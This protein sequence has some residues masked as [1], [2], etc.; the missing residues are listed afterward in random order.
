MIPS[1]LLFF[2]A[3]LSIVAPGAPPNIALVIVDDLAMDAMN[4]YRHLSG[5]VKV[6]STLGLH[7][8]FKHIPTPGID[9]LAAEGVLFSR[10]YTSAP[11]CSPSRYS[12]LVGRYPS[13]SK[14]AVEQSLKHPNAWKVTEGMGISPAQ[15]VP[16]R[17]GDGSR[18]FVYNHF[19]IWVGA[20][21]REEKTMA[22]ALSEAGFRT[23]LVGK[24]H[25]SWRQADPHAC[26]MSP[27]EYEEERKLVAETAGFDFVDALNT[28]NIQSSTKRGNRFSHNPEHTLHHAQ[29]FVLD[30]TAAQEPWFLYMG[31]TLPHPPNARLALSKYSVS[32]TPAGPGKFSG[33]AQAAE[34]RARWQTQVAKK[35]D[36]SVTAAVASGYKGSW[37]KNSHNSASIVWLDA[38][39]QEWV[40]WLKAQSLAD[41]TLIVFTSDH[42]LM[43]KRTCNEHGIRVPLIFRGPPSLV[44]QGATVHQ[45]VALHDLAATFLHLVRLPKTPQASGK[46]RLPRPGI[47]SIL[48]GDGVSVWP[49]LGGQAV[50]ESLF[51]EIGYDR[52]VVLGEKGLK[53]VDRD[54]DPDRPINTGVDSHRAMKQLYNLTEDPSETNNLLSRGRLID[55]RNTG[56]RVA[57]KRLE[58]LLARHIDATSIPPHES[59]KQQSDFRRSAKDVDGSA[60]KGRSAISNSI[61]VHAS[62]TEFQ[63]KRTTAGTLLSTNATAAAFFDELSVGVA[64]PQSL[65][66][67]AGPKAGQDDISGRKEVDSETV[68][69][70]VFHGEALLADGGHIFGSQQ[71]MRERIAA[72]WLSL[73]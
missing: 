7:K 1:Y 37:E 20:P 67:R 68:E 32:D 62:S 13:R 2:L 14:T 35:A 50:H 40:D 23:G 72:D 29:R 6:P 61:S 17:V 55:E 47:N 69:T 49:T 36:D 43:G 41:K 54:F 3:H 70:Q 31:L 26:S 38:V 42:G 22:H 15:K 65:Y 52:A 10:A 51:C 66:S 57:L 58:D 9:Q 56:A 21:P 39:V 60:G 44:P 8:L 19:N 34:R 64:P 28:C 73:G 18:V 4:V 46:K 27:S 11:I 16:G 24:W 45:V 33:Q 5:P 48:E 63:E 30:A 25:L 71:S 53:L 59:Q 12:L